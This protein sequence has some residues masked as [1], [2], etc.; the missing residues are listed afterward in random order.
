MTTL[1]E[2]NELKQQ[3]QAQEEKLQEFYSSIDYADDMERVV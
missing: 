3:V 1:T 2:L